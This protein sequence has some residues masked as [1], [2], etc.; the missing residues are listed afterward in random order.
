VVERLI[1]AGATVYRTDRDGEITVETD[2][3]HV[4][5][6]TFTGGKK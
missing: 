4:F 2:G 5:V 1:A 6:G 3:E